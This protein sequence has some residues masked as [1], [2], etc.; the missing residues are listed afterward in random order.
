MEGFVASA[1]IERALPRLA[2][3]RR[4]PDP[5]RSTSHLGDQPSEVVEVLRADSPGDTRAAIRDRWA[6]F[7]ERWSELTF[8]LFD[9]QSWR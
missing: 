3:H 9:A 2:D 6:A 1:R 8:Y 5:G 4:G 7:R